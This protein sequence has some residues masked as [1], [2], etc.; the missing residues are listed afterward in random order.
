[1][2]EHLAQI[3]CSRLDHA[4]LE[5][6]QTDGIAL[7]PSETIDRNRDRFCT[8]T[9]VG[10]RLGWFIHD[11]LLLLACFLNMTGACKLFIY[12]ISFKS[13]WNGIDRHL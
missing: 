2:A 7:I 4:D 9:I 6:Q 10:T 11:S 13:M 1:M 12:H 8:V 3:K 5:T